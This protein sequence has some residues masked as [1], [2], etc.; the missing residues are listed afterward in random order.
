MEAAHLQMSVAA[1]LTIVPTNKKNPNQN[2]V[3][4]ELNVTIRLLGHHKVG[5]PLI[6]LRSNQ[7][8]FGSQIQAH[9]FRAAFEN[10]TMHMT[11]VHQSL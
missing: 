5:F 1:H 9:I 6:G 8:S 10:L 2:L 3:P 11:S 4:S 7:K